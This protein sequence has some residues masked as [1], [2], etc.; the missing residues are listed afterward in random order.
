LRSLITTAAPDDLARF[1][2]SPVGESLCGLLPE[3]S[4]FVSHDVSADANDGETL[5]RR[6]VHAISQLLVTLAG[7]QPLLVVFEDL[8][9]S[10]ETTLEFL[11]HLARQARSAPLLL[12][13]TY[14]TDDATPDLHGLLAAL[15]RERLASELHLQPLLPAE[16]ERML[17]AIFSLDRPVRGEVLDLLY[18]LTEGNAFFVEEVLKALVVAGDLSSAQSA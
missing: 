18:A 7:Q 13:L 8:H 5:K 17:R 4:A 15:D 14:R 3:L 6:R 2:A 10:D 9:W 1:L 16:V 12:L 11:R